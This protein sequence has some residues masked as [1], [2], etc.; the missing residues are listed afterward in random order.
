[1]QEPLAD[2]DW[3]A[4]TVVK[5]HDTATIEVDTRSLKRGD[6]ICSVGLKVRFARAMISGRSRQ[7]GIVTGNTIPV[8]VLG[9]TEGEGYLEIWTRDKGRLRSLPIIVRRTL[10]LANKKPEYEADDASW[11]AKLDED[12]FNGWTET[13]FREVSMK[14]KDVCYTLSVHDHLKK[15]V[16]WVALNILKRTDGQKALNRRFPQKEPTKKILS[17]MDGEEGVIPPGKPYIFGEREMQTGVYALMP[18]DLPAPIIKPIVDWAKLA[19]AKAG[20]KAPPAYYGAWVVICLYD[21]ENNR[22]GTHCDNDY[23]T[24]EYNKIVLMTAN[25]KCIPRTEPHVQAEGATLRC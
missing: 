14:L 12:Y 16:W 4:A 11:A 2:Q 18:S 10:E 5:V 22:L 8:S 15:I 9:L 19:L 7:H 3:K 1:M 24:K 6:K 23:W 20:V 21:S 17:W 25:R 13:P